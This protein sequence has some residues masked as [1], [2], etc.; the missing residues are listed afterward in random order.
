ME[1]FRVYKDV[2]SRRWS[3]RIYEV[4]NFGR[5]RINGEIINPPVY[6]NGYQF[7]G[8]FLVHRAVAEVFIPNPENKPFVDHINTNP[9][10]NR[11]N[12]LRWVTAKENQNNTLTKRHM[13]DGSKGIAPWN[14]GCTGW[15]KGKHWRFVNGKRMYYE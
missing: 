8:G 14:K 15:N 4:S 13:S 9:L 12:N 11:V 5:V 1:E 10:D 3:H 7:I 6:N 2:S